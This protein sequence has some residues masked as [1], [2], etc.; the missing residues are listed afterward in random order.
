MKTFK[1]RNTYKVFFA[2][3]DDDILE[4]LSNFNTFDE[5][6]TFLNSIGLNSK[7]LLN[8]R[9][10]DGYVYWVIT[11]ADT[12]VADWH[13]TELEDYMCAKSKFDWTEESES[14][15]S[16]EA[17]SIEDEFDFLK[18]I[19]DKVLTLETTV[20]EN[21]AVNVKRYCDVT[22]M[23]GKDSKKISKELDKIIAKQT[24]SEMTSLSDYVKNNTSVEKETLLGYPD[25]ND[26]DSIFNRKW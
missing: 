9:N 18:S 8:K 7:R 23:F 21:D 4:D 6:E 17:K 20:H 25:F 11:E 19:D 22:T 5:F 10:R 1:F 26:L 14:Y 2:W 24:K 3:D 16:S 12:V 13:H 15:F